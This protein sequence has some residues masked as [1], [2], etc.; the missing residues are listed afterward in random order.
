MGKC[1]NVMEGKEVMVDTVGSRLRSRRP[2]NSNDVRLVKNIN[3]YFIGFN[4]YELT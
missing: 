2:L 4:V 1:G 3:S